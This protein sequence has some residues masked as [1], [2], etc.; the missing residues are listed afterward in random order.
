M[1][2]ENSFIPINEDENNVLR[3]AK[4]AVKNY[5]ADECLAFIQDYNEMINHRFKEIKIPENF[6]IDL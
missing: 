4:S 5:S 6:R 2:Q 3:K 1:N